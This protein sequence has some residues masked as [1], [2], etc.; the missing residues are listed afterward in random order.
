MSLKLVVPGTPPPHGLSPDPPPGAFPL[1][2][3]P[4]EARKL[5]LP[6]PLLTGCVFVVS[7]TAMTLIGFVGSAGADVFVAAW[8]LLALAYGRASLHLLAQG[9]WL[10]WLIPGFSLL[11]VL[12]STAPGETVRFGVENALTVACAV[13][14]A[15]LLRPRAMLAALTLS[16]LATSVVSIGLGGRTID[17]LTKAIVF[18]GVFTSKNEVGFFSSLMFIA[19]VA[20]GIDRR[21]P[22]PLRLLGWGAVLLSLPLLVLSRSA[23]SVASVA[24]GAAALV[25]GLI[26]SRLDRAGRARMIAAATLAMLPAALLLVGIGGEAGGFVLDALGRDATLTGRTDLWRYA[27]KIIADAPLL[28]QGFQ[29]FWRHD[30][31]D[32]ETLWASFGVG[33]RTGFHFHN[34]YVETAVELGYAG[35]ALLVVTLLGFVVGTVRWSWQTGSV[36]AAFWV[37]VL[38]CLIA[39]S[40]AEVDALQPFQVGTFI[41]YA[42]GTYAATKPRD[43]APPVP[44]PAV[45]AFSP[46][47]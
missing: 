6:P 45:A 20:V 18:V 14:S 33:S 12:W 8:G 1:A 9:P 25:F 37:A 7:F 38:A 10:V 21:Q 39:R 42:A 24:V 2:F 29:A 19:A 36:P 32:A 23:T 13:L 22:A 43:D 40:F 41:L 44:R 31:V 5:A 17:P 3:S 15:R 47:G 28:G 46:G 35:V 27:D 11:S 34:T 30:S 4:P 26:L 16:L